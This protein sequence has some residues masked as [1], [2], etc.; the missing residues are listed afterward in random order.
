MSDYDYY[1][2]ED[3]QRLKKR[4]KRLE[5]MLKAQGTHEHDCT[6]IT[7]RK[8]HPVSGLALYPTDCNCWLS[9]EKED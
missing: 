9:Q 8:P 2:R 5:K 4:V 1:A 6:Y 3:I 7:S